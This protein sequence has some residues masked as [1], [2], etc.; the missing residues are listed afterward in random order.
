MGLF[1]SAIHIKK[2]K[3]FKQSLLR[4]FKSKGLVPATENDALFAYRLASSPKSGWVTLTLP[5]NELETNWTPDGAAELAESLKTY[6]IA[7][8]VIDSDVLSLELFRADGRRDVINIGA[9]DYGLTESAGVRELWEPLLAENATWEQVGEVYNGDY[10]FS[11]EALAD[12]APLLGM[13]AEVAARP[14]EDL[15]GDNSNITDLYLKK[16]GKKSVSLN[17][18]FKQIFGEALEPLGFK[19]IKSKYPYFVRLIGGEILHI[20]TYYNVPTGRK[21]YK[22]FNVLGGVATL[23]RPRIDLGISPRNNS[24]WLIS[25][26]QIYTA[27]NPI[28]MKSEF[29]KSIFS[30]PYKEDS[31]DESV[32]HSLKI[33]REFILPI[34]DETHELNS[35]IE[36]FNRFNICLGKP[37]DLNYFINA[38]HY[39]GLLYVKTANLDIGFFDKVYREPELYTKYM[40]ELERRRIANISILRSYGLNIQH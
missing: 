22:E 34:L 27:L 12:I 1:F 7:S 5:G 24:S 18:A 37:S 9:P 38:P 17:S 3:Q 16:A 20:I 29:G 23:Y 10:T 13:D 32:K 35:C 4:F 28:K 31:V 25:N 11:E 6:C 8:H 2:T 15:D 36:Y 26:W 19:K 33:T 30:F 40:M 39:E 14:Y 21:G